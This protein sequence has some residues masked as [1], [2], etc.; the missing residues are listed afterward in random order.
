MHEKAGPLDPS[1]HENFALNAVASST[2]CAWTLEAAS[3]DHPE[4]SK[5]KEEALYSIAPMLTTLSVFHFPISW[6]KD[7]APSNIWVMSVTW[8]VSQAEMSPLN[9]ILSLNAA[10]IFVTR[11]VSHAGMIP[12][13]VTFVP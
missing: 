9:E 3:P 2:I 8:D 10:F 1:E 12:R 5:S 4:I 13:A 6:L 11:D 7:F